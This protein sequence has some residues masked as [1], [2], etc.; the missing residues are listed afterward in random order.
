MLSN[1]AIHHSTSS[2]AA[3][4]L[5]VKKKDGTWR[6]CVDYIYLNSLT[7]KHDYPM[8]IIDELLDELYGSKFLSKIDLRAGYHQIRMKESDV[9]YTGFRTHQGH[10][11]FLVMPFGLSIVPATF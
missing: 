11:E 1:G 6:M 8:P 3:P 7:V 5:L 2:F 10:Y 9:P 4:V